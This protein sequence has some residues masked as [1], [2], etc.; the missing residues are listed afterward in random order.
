MGNLKTNIDYESNT[1]TEEKRGTNPVSFS[2]VQ[3]RI[4]PPLDSLSTWEVT[5]SLSFKEENAFAE[6]LAVVMAAGESKRK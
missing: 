4:T 5:R 3:A 2:V 1:E 6:S